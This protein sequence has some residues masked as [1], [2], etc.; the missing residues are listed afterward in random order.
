MQGDI[1]NLADLDRLYE[2]V[3]VKHGRLDIVVANAGIGEWDPLGSIS[4]AH[5]DHTFGVN[6]KG[7]VFTVQ[8]ALAL[9]ED[10]GSVI[11]I[12]SIAGSKGIPA[13]V[14]TM[15]L[16]PPFGHLRGPGSWT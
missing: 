13:L 10:G 1:A 8:E 4:E 12:G 16:K 3:R 11:M 15:P 7:T 5:F 6:V 2:G 9:L 14:S